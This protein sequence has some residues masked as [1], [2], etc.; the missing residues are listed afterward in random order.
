MLEGLKDLSLLITV[1]FQCL[2]S[3][4]SFLL[5][6]IPHLNLHPHP[7]YPPTSLLCTSVNFVSLS[8]LQ[9]FMYSMCPLTISK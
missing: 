2:I 9:K 7:L 4:L 3:S 8:S 1:L 6:S 5:I